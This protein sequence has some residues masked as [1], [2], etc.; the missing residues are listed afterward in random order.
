MQGIRTKVS[1]VSLD[2]LR[3]SYLT[4]KT[5]TLAVNYPLRRN[6]ITPIGYYRR[7]LYRL[8]K[9]TGQCNNTKPFLQSL[10]SAGLLNYRGCRGGRNKV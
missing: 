8:R 5:K 6:D 9:V 4:L 1:N 3:P 7:T 2:C 10:K